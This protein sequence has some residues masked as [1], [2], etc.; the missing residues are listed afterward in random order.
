MRRRGA[1]ES[2]HNNALHLSRSALASSRSAS[3]R[4]SPLTAVFGRQVTP[5]RLT[6]LAVALL[7]YGC[8]CLESCVGAAQPQGGQLTALSGL[9]PALLYQMQGTTG[10]LFAVLVLQPDEPVGW[11]GSSFSVEC[12]SASETITWEHPAGR[13]E[14]RLSYDGATKKV[15]VGAQEWSADTTNTFMVVFDSRWTFTARALEVVAGGTS[16]DTLARIQQALSGDRE[17]TSLR[18]AL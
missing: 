1:R 2:L 10:T 6:V 13:S 17:V 16:Q 8:L 11:N 4:P 12:A 7:S 5:P 15:R 14:L 9:R 3:P 18:V